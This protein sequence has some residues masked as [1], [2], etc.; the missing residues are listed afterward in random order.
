MDT[1]SSPTATTSRWRNEGT[2]EYSQELP[3]TP[4]EQATALYK[5]LRENLQ[6]SRQIEEFLFDLDQQVE[7]LENKG[8]DIHGRIVAIRSLQE[9]QQIGLREI[10]ETLLPNHPDHKGKTKAEPMPGPSTTAQPKKEEPSRTTRCSSFVYSLGSSHSSR[11][12][13][14]VRAGFS[15]GTTAPPPQAASTPT[16][17]TASH[18]PKLSSPDAYD[19]KKRGRPARLWLSRVLAWIEPSRA[20]FPD[21]QALILYMLHLLK[22]DAANWA[23]PHLQKVLSRRRGAIATVGEFVDEFG[24][25]FDNPHAGRAAKRKIHELTQDSLPTKS[26]AEYTT[27]FRNLMANL[28]WDNT[29]FLT[30]YRRGL[31]WKVKE[32]MSQR[33]NQPRTLEAWITVAIQIDNICWENKASRPPR[34]SNPPKK[35]TVT[36]P[37]TVTIKK[38][39][40]ALPN[41]VDEVE[42]KWRREGG[43]CIKCGASGHT[44]KD[45]KVGWKPAKAKEEKGKVTEEEEKSEL[46]L[47]KEWGWVLLCVLQPWTQD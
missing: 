29:A 15:F 6:T 7:A 34:T 16:P 11:D 44:I 39:P 20:A 1:N 3:G 2:V 23:Q 46:D 32:L 45:C 9:N 31:H 47:G 18:I 24:A 41:Y 38:D 5:M 22:D 13:S 8:D 28:D 10:H 27:K 21:E 4:A 42:R 19:G 36:T 40:K 35:V 33:E 43:L 30:S 25:T 37:T 12:P 26:T 14:P 17:V